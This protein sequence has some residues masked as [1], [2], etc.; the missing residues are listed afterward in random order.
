MKTRIF[1]WPSN[2]LGFENFRTNKMRLKYMDMIRHL[3]RFRAIM[4]TLCRGKIRAKFQK[5]SKFVFGTHFHSLDL[6]KR[7]LFSM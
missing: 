7:K 2:G 4:G 6:T 1:K 5:S 3:S